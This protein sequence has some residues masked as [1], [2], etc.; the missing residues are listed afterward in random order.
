MDILP[1][2]VDELFR[3]PHGKEA[4]RRIM[5]FVRAM[6]KEGVP[7]R[8]IARALVSSICMIAHTEYIK[9][10]PDRL[11]AKK[12]VKTAGD[13]LLTWCEDT[14]TIE[15]RAM[16]QAKHEAEGKSGPITQ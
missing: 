14:E 8:A 15:E 7:T 10:G 6:E 11:W 12:F 4:E 1:P 2:V 16:A 5:L 3:D 13:T 9:W